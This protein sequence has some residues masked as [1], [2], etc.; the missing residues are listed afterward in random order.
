[1]NVWSYKERSVQKRIYYRNN[2]RNTSFKRKTMKRLKWCSHVIKRDIDH[3]VDRVPMTTM[4]KDHVE[5]C[6]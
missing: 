2:Q 1:M 3:M 4:T 6:L 5:R